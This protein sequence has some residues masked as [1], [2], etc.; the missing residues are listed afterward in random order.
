MLIF[1]ARLCINQRQ[2]ETG[3]P[4]TSNK[5]T[6]KVRVD[7]KRNR[8]YCIVEGK[9]TKAD[10]EGFYTDVRFG[11]ADLK[12]GFNVITDLT[13]CH[14]GH[15]AAIPTFRKVMHYLISNGVHEVVRVVNPQS[16]IYRQAIN[17]AARIQGYKPVY[18]NTVKEAEELLDRPGGRKGLRFSLLNADIHFAA[19]TAS[20]MGKLVDISTSGCAVSS[21]ADQPLVG[22]KL[23]LTISLADQQS[24]DKK[25]EIAAVVVRLFDGGFAVEFSDFE[26]SEKEKLWACLVD[27]TRRD[28]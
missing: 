12:P 26:D 22:Q 3:T 2:Q 20:A 7:M 1:L 25:F 27:E 5:N 23:L 10:M 17:I 18:V 24:N 13:K 8:L 28:V 6:L 16:M 15:L 14:I 11:V 19:D 21:A 9:I 4:M